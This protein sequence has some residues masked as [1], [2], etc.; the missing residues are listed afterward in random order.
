MTRWAVLA[1]VLAFVPDVAFA[2]KPVVVLLPFDTQA[3]ADDLIVSAVEELLASGRL[4]R[5]AKMIAGSKLRRRVRAKPEHAVI[6][7]GGDFGCLAKLGRRAKATRVIVGY[8]A[9]AGAGVQVE[10]HIIDVPSEELIDAMT[11]TFASVE[12]VEMVLGNAVYTLVGVSTPGT[13]MVPGASGTVVVDGN[14]V[15]TGPGPYEVPAGGHD[16]RAQGHSEWVMVHPR[17]T[18]SIALPA[19]P[20]PTVAPVEEE[21]V[22]AV[23]SAAAPETEPEETAPPEVVEEVAAVPAPPEIAVAPPTPVPPAPASVPGAKL[24]YWG[25]GLTAV[26]AGLMGAGAGLGARRASLATG[27]VDET[28]VE[29]AERRDAAD[30]AATGA[31]VL[32]LAGGATALLGSALLTWGVLELP[33]ASGEV[34]LDAL[35][36]TGMAIGG[37]GVLLTGVGAGFGLQ[38]LA[39]EGGS[40]GETQVEKVKRIDDANSAAEM[41]NS[42]FVAGASAMVVG[43]LL[44]ALDLLVLPATSVSVATDGDGVQATVGFQW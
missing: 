13:I 10:L 27:P 5:G 36:Y 34:E 12:V 28:Q 17:D 33:E 40:A 35:T 39:L 18:V 44:V 9:P 4:V 6:K 30:G 25:L 14:I 22:A 43:A 1:V 19:A 31:N 24:S 38:R 16:V 26:G 2:R 42:M 37:A 21:L 32:L 29:F 23:V 8:A 15:G 3:G 20:E 41:A 11:L 7:C